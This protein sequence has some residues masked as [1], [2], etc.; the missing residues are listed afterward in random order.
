[1]IKKIILTD[2]PEVMEKKYPDKL[3]VTR[4]PSEFISSVDGLR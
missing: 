4:D 3:I 2:Y 1:M